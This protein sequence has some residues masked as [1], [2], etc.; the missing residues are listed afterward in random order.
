MY[1][2]GCIWVAD[3]ALL[4]IVG[5]ACF[6]CNVMETALLLRTDT[7]R[8]RASSVERSKQLC[9]H[10]HVSGLLIVAGKSGFAVGRDCMG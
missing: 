7:C 9:A 10:R 3:A 4:T 1:G 2:V 5:S 6:V 8:R